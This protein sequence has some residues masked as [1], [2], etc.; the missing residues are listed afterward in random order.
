MLPK[1]A[2]SAKEFIQIQRSALEGKIVSSSLHQWI[3]LIF[4]FKQQG[5]PA[6]EAVNVFY[7]LTYEGA[8]NLDAIT[9]ENVRRATEAQIDHFGQTPSQIFKKPHPPR[10]AV[11]S[12]PFFSHIFSDSYRHNIQ[13]RAVEISKAPIVFIGAPE[14][15]QP[16]NLSVYGGTT[17]RVITVDKQR[18][19][20]SHRWLGE[21]PSN[22][23]FLELDPTSPQARRR[24]G[25]PFASGLPVS[26]SLF[27]VSSDAR[28][29]F[30]CGHWDNSFKASLL[31]SGKHFQSVSWHKDIVTCLSL[32]R[33]GRELL[34]GSK[35]TTLALW[36]IHS[37]GGV[38]EQPSQIL[39]GHVEEVTCACINVEFDV[40]VSG[41]KDGRL[42][43]HSLRK[44]TYLRSIEATNHSIQL[45]D[46][47]GDKI[48]SYSSGDMTIRLHTLNGVVLKCWETK[49]HPSQ[50]LLTRGGRFLICGSV[51]G[52]LTCYDVASRVQIYQYMCEGPITSL[53]VSNEEFD[54]FVGLENGKMLI[55]SRGA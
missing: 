51:E 10:T 38:A 26:A 5:K 2:G 41:A 27:C 32:A 11:D 8:V 42:I 46:A 24:F 53:Q 39:H 48:A 23:C 37:R 47:K 31:D 35:D 21:V 18:V 45:I 1:W 50:L 12:N 55:F 16:S 13:V 7:F 15:F 22:S 14:V 19:A 9:D 28:I 20:A 43:I 40:A 52:Y 4:G 54:L 17:E 36:P 44:G 6:I 30:S 29:V 34:T 25:I 3:D 33:D 49:S